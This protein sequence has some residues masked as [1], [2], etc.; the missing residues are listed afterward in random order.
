MSR[1]VVS[2][3]SKLVVR[4]GEGKG[5]RKDRLHA[6]ITLSIADRKLAATVM[7]E[8]K[9]A[10]ETRA[11]ALPPREARVVRVEKRSEIESGTLEGTIV[12]VPVTA[13]N[14]RRLP[15]IVDAI[16]AARP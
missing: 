5:P 14:R 10:L 4:T 6:A 11:A 9:G 2:E 1:I 8:V 3:G 15:E 16:R 7:R 13:R 12:I